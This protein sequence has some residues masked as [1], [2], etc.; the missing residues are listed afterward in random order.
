MVRLLEFLT[1]GRIGEIHLWMTAQELLAV[2]GEPEA[3]SLTKPPIWKYESLQL[4]MYWGVVREISLSADNGTL[5]LPDP[6][7][8]EDWDPSQGLTLQAFQD[9]ILPGSDVVCRTTEESQP[10]ENGVQTIAIPPL[11]TMTFEGWPNR[12]RLGSIVIR[13]VV[14]DPFRQIGVAVSVETFET[15]K[16]EAMRRRI[17]TSRLCAEKLQEYA[18]T[19]G[20]Q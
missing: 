6:F 8:F 12:S 16:E 9:N 13:E 15:L 1:T 11:A 3:R 18:R 19:L 7:H 20:R 17:S 5:S 2:L 4:V 10:E 14:A